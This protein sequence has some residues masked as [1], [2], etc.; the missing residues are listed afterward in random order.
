MLKFGEVGQ[1]ME[2][3]T[4]EK[5]GS[6]PDNNQSID[7]AGTIDW[8]RRAGPVFKYGIVV[9][10]LLI[11]L[12]VASFSF[13]LTYVLLETLIVCSGLSI[14][15]G[16][17]G[18]TAKVKLPDQGMVLVGVAAVA[19]ILFYFVVREMDDRYVNVKIA[20][21]VVGANIDFIGDESYLG[22]F[23]EAEK[24]YRFVVFGKEIDQPVLALRIE[25]PNSSE[26]HFDCID[27]K[28]L[29]PYL[30]S[31]RTIVW[32]FDNNTGTLINQENKKR[33]A[34]VGRCREER[35]PIRDR[36]VR[37]ERPGFGFALPLISS[38]YAKG[39]ELLVNKNIPE[40]L[41]L[42][43]SNASYIRRDARDQ[44]ARNEVAAVKPMLVKFA[45]AKIS[46]RSRL[47]ILVA[48]AKMLRENKKLRTELIKA[49]SKDDL[50]R[51]VKASVDSDRTIRQYVSEFLYDLGDPRTIS[52]VFDLYP[53]ITGNESKNLLL[54]IRGVVPYANAPQRSDIVSRI[55]NLNTTNDATTNEIIR[56]I[57][58]M[59]K[60]RD[61]AF[62]LVSSVRDLERAIKLAK[63]IEEKKDLKYLPHVYLAENGWYVVSLGGHM[64]KDE[65][66]KRVNYAIEAGIASDAFVWTSYFIDEPIYSK[67]GN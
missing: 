19:V 20:G 31:G 32:Q 53:S 12:G 5:Q 45:E 21:D 18:S 64:K 35:G 48:F 57:T 50:L 3:N 65:A 15:L 22:S 51:M 37:E 58:N 14:I 4:V 66:Q 44:L 39:E 34:E 56:Y 11:A 2:S 46:Y 6:I 40:L 27:K 62:P 60:G 30:G 7:A 16:A 55:S 9:G 24:K 8:H 47:G 23:Q 33:V 61:S 10:F 36:D 28:H 42:L 41:D 67:S 59:A 38:A 25:M 17:F 26:A 52:L 1:H 43:E 49:L 63:Q 54:I 13:S 29:K